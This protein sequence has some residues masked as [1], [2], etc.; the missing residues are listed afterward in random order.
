MN[1]L[2]FLRPDGSEPT[3]G[4]GDDW[5]TALAYTEDKRAQ[6]GG[7]PPVDMPSYLE[8]TY[9]TVL[10]LEGEIIAWGQLWFQLYGHNK[11]RVR[12][13]AAVTEDAILVWWQPGRRKLIETFHAAFIDCVDW[14]ASSQFC[15]DLAWNKASLANQN[16]KFAIGDA[17]TEIA[18]F[19]RKSDGH[20][21]RR[22]MTLAYTYNQRLHVS[23]SSPPRA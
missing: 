16:G 5:A 13:K 14:Q 3:A 6:E 2:A 20:A 10:G 12:A 11:Q 22:A 15:M 7:I 23:R 9:A 18:P 19:F 8:S 4:Q 17:H 1:K 21:N